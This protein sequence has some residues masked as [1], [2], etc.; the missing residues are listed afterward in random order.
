MADESKADD[1]QSASGSIQD[2]LPPRYI[3][4]VVADLNRRINTEQAAGNEE[5]TPERTQ[6]L[7]TAQATLASY[8]TTGQ[9]SDEALA[10]VHQIVTREPLPPITRAKPDTEPPVLADRPADSTPEP[11]ETQP[12]IESPAIPLA[13]EPEAIA[14][15]TPPQQESAAKPAVTPQ[16]AVQVTA[17]VAKAMGEQPATVR[18]PPRQTP[19]QVTKQARPAQ[20]AS[21]PLLDASRKAELQ[22]DRK[23]ATQSLLR[24]KIENVASVAWTRFK[25]AVGFGATAATEQETPPPPRDTARPAP[26]PA[27]P[28]QGFPAP[29]AAPVTP[30]PA[31]T[32]PPPPRDT[33][34]PEPEATPQQTVQPP[35][36]AEMPATPPVQPADGSGGSRPPVPPVT[37]AA[38]AD[39]DPTPSWKD[40]Y[41][42]RRDEGE[43]RVRATVGATRDRASDFL[44]DQS[45]AWED[46]RSGGTARIQA[47]D[48]AALEAGGTTR[49]QHPLVEAASRRLAEDQ[50]LARQNAEEFRARQVSD[51]PLPPGIQSPEAFYA[52]QRLGYEPGDP[53]A[54]S[55]AGRRDRSD[56]PGR[57]WEDAGSPDLASRESTLASM[58]AA[59]ELLATGSAV[60]EH[61]EPLASQIRRHGDQF[62]PADAYVVQQ[63]QA[64]GAQAS[65]VP[66]RKAGFAQRMMGI[67]DD[68]EDGLRTA[69]MIGA[70]EY[71]EHAIRQYAAAGSEAAAPFVGDA[72]AA[73]AGSAGQAVAGIAGGAGTVA[74]GVATANPLLVAK[75]VADVGAEL[76]K[77]PGMLVQ[78]G[79]ALIGSADQIKEFSSVLANAFAVAELRTMQRQ[80]GSAQRTGE[81][82]ANLI[83]ARQDLADTLQPIKDS[84]TNVLSKDIANGIRDLNAIV[85]ILREWGQKLG[86]LDSDEDLAK[87]QTPFQETVAGIKAGGF[88]AQN[89]KGEWVQHDLEGGFAGQGMGGM[90][91]RDEKPGDPV[92]SGVNF[93]DRAGGQSNDNRPNGDESGAA[94]QRAPTLE[95]RD[96]IDKRRQELR[97]RGMAHRAEDRKKITDPDKLID[98]DNTTKK[99]E[100]AQQ[101]A[102]RGREI[103]RQQAILAEQREKFRQ[104]EMQRGAAVPQDIRNAS[105]SPHPEMPGPFRNRQGQEIP[106][107]HGQPN[108]N[109]KPG[110]SGV[111]GALA[112]ATS[113]GTASA[114]YLLWKMA[115]GELQTDTKPPNQTAGNV[116]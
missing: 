93:R 88:S 18:E 64:H 26:E 68:D 38:P 19:Q 100:R 74:A 105:P 109:E 86:L 28:P 57:T 41:Q 25:Q 6:Q 15:E 49:P 10:S 106:Q 47:T 17:A 35:A 85:S 16:E 24:G 3:G 89:E 23:A 12:Q 14:A 43:G 65:V 22:A 114:L 63:R 29:T 34:R 61:L 11:A 69:K 94:G 81:A 52:A 33:A 92:L 76:I 59:Q 67:R 55:A 39:D 20:P 8:V 27:A 111:A 97:D 21:Q 4:D 103:A 44:A 37:T 73:I 72:P 80:F 66:Q 30:S 1:L 104:S 13:T 107:V 83:D 95:E 40:N 87:R 46:R 5:L 53:Q 42:R 36:P 78:W 9:L 84:T 45:I 32:I 99:I 48:Q 51:K 79:D 77:L 116:P 7:S 60:P 54:P 113:G 56:L 50:G 102:D 58:Q 115:K 70:A 90:Q 108:Q 71:G 75:G 101:M 31:P 82:S 110:Y 98:F 62:T 91:R 112:A 96:A 2:N